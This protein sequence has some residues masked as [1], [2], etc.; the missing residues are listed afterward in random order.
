MRSSSFL[1]TPSARRATYV[2]LCAPSAVK[3][4]STPSARRA[5]TGRLPGQAD[6]T[7][8]IHALCEEGDIC[9]V[10]VS[11]R[12]VR[13]LSTP[14]ARRAT[15]ASCAK[16][17]VLG[18]FYPRP[19]RG[20]RRSPATHARPS[21][22]FLSTPSARR[23]TSVLSSLLSSRTISIHA[24]CEEGDIRRNR[25]KLFSA[26]FYP[27]PLRGGRP[28][29]LRQRGRELPDFYP[30]PLRG[31]R[32]ACLCDSIALSQISIHALCEEGDD[33][34]G[35]LRHHG[36]QFLSTPSARRATSIPGL[37]DHH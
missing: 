12:L 8:S 29:C 21:R 37:V 19:L 28:P 11:Y 14:S 36:G 13:F 16:I 17:S 18:N 31:G 23:A 30:R 10:V 26:D 33:G 32:L 25:Q 1:S 9:P 22:E 5:T 3:F 35:L 4:L 27:R 34:I 24:L 6:Q 7:I 15:S 20:G 2:I